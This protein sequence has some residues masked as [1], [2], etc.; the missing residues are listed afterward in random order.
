MGYVKANI[1]SEVYH[2]TK[3]AN[4]PSILSDK[5]IKRMGDSE[6]WFCESIEDMKRYMEYTV[7]NEGKPYIGVGGIP[8]RYPKFQPE[9][10]SILKIEPRYRIG[11]WVRWMQE[12]PRESSAELKKEAEEFSKLKIGFRGDVQIGKFEILDAN[13]RALSEFTRRGMLAKELRK[14]YPPGTRLEIL[15]MEDPQPVEDGMRGVIEH[16]DDQANMHMKWDNGRGIAVDPEI[17]TFRILTAEELETEKQTVLVEKYCKSINEEI[18]P[19]LDWVKLGESYESGDYE[20]TKELLGKLHEAFVS[21]Y[22]TDELNEG[23]GI[24]KIPAVVQGKD[25][26]VCIALLDIDTESS[27]E[28]WDTDFITPFGI[29]QHSEKHHPL[30]A[31]FAKAMCPYNY[32]YTMSNDGDIHTNYRECPEQIKAMVEEAR[33]YSTEQRGEILLE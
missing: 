32:W 11:N 30:A 12:I 15:H 26:T 25:G 19:D 16:I 27:G 3:R 28:H 20:Y 24:V 13:G 22:G 21:V 9:D 7:L 18:L 17:D 14:S 31:E 29:Y 23:M 10:Y 5:K 33:A 8:Q 4:L 1:P 6:C 2:L